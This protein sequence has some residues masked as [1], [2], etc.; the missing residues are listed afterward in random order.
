MRAN[1]VTAG[2]FKNVEEYDDYINSWNSLVNAEA[3]FDG[4]YIDIFKQSDAMIT[5]S[6]SF[7]AEYQ[8][9]GKPLLLLESGKQLYND[10]GNEL[11]K[12]LYRCKHDDSKAI[13]AFIDKVL[14][15]KDS[16]KNIRKEFFDEH[17]NYYAKSGKLAND[18]IYSVFKNSLEFIGNYK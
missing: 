6:V 13:E 18:N 12:I 10:F 2:I 3:V 7:L 17:L 14:D 15:D 1:S 9:T 4:N 16:M 5:D 8:F 11:L